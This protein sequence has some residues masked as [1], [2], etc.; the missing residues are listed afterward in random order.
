MCVCV[1]VCVRERE[2]ERERERKREKERQRAEGGHAKAL[3]AEDHDLLATIR[4]VDLSTLSVVLVL[5]RELLVGK[6][7]K[8]LRYA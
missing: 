4:D 3:P 1:C 5:T 8:H 2:R 7:V 6:L